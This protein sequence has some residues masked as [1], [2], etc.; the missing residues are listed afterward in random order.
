MPYTRKISPRAEYRLRR[1]EE[2]NSSPSL[3]EKFPKLKTLQVSLNYFDSIGEVRSGG[4][5]Y[6]VNVAQGKSRFC[7]NCVNAD[8]AGGDFDLSDQLAQAVAK[9]RKLVEGEAR[10]QGIRHNKE[11][12]QDIPCQAILRFK[13][14]LGY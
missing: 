13:F 8:C 3:A 2:I 6:K 10:C 12:K 14:V 7:F 11:R 4:M 9:K 1:N 5:K